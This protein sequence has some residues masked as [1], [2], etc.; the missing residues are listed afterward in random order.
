MLLT[1]HRCHPSWPVAYYSSPLSLL[2]HYL[3]CFAASANS[4]FP[5]STQWRRLRFLLPQRIC[6]SVVAVADPFAT[7]SAIATPRWT[8]AAYWAP[9]SSSSLDPV[10]RR[11]SLPLVVVS[12]SITIIPPLRRKLMPLIRQQKKELNI[13]DL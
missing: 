7:T 2:P 3:L 13:T 1:C 8:P 6:A 5:F 12:I 11:N 9:T 4:F 10:A